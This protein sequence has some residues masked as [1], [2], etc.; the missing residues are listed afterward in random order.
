[1]H[2][3]HHLGVSSIIQYREKLT[4]DPINIIGPFDI[5]CWLREYCEIHPMNY[6]YTHIRRKLEIKLVLMLII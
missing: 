3:D 1:M 4:S 6:R 2:A 5:E